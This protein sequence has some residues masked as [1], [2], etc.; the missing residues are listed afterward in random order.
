MTND[1]DGAALGGVKTGRFTVEDS[2]FVEV[3]AL[4]GSHVY[5]WQTSPDSGVEAQI[6]LSR[7]GALAFGRELV[8]RLSA[9]QPAF[10][11][12]GVREALEQ[13]EASGID[14]EHSG[15]RHARCRDIARRAL[16][17]TPIPEAPASVEPVAETIGWNPTHEVEDRVY[18]HDGD[19]IGSHSPGFGGG[20]L[21]EALSELWSAVRGCDLRM[22][23]PPLTV[24]KVRKAL[25]H[26]QRGGSGE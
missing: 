6:T 11:A 4:I 2:L 12:A 23:V 20:D 16:A 18:P 26:D 8:A 24:A 9:P 7:D 17:A 25:S 15:D 22:S 14:G 19:T 13:I 3:R 21:R 10:D 1:K 5:L